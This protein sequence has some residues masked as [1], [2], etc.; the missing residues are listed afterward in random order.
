[1]LQETFVKDVEVTDK[2]GGKEKRLTPQ[3]AFRGAFKVPKRKNLQ[4]ES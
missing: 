1:M 2:T 4:M 3:E